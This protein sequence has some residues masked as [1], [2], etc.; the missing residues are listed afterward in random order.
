MSWL[1]KT[2]C[3]PLQTQEWLRKAVPFVK[4]NSHLSTLANG[5]SFSGDIPFLLGKIFP[6]KEEIG[7]VTLALVEMS[8]GGCYQR[9][10]ICIVRQALLA[11][12]KQLS[13]NPPLPA[14]PPSPLP[15]PPPSPPPEGPNPK[16]TS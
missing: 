7:V 1:F 15:P 6:Q 12:P 13:P 10:F 3:R 9:D 16:T 11:G 2:N 8:A 14:P 4:R 5:V